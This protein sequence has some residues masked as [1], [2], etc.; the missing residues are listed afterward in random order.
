MCLFFLSYLLNLSKIRGKT[1]ADEIYL[2][3]FSVVE[4]LAR[5]MYDVTNRWTLSIIAQ[6]YIYRHQKGMN[7]IYHGVNFFCRGGTTDVMHFLPLYEI[8]MLDYF[9]IENGIF[10]DVGAHVGRY[11]LFV[12]KSLR[13]GYVYSFEP[14][15]R[16]FEV[17]MKNIAANDVHNITPLRIALSNSQGLTYLQLSDLNEGANSLVDVG[18]KNRLICVRTDR[19][20]DII[21]KEGIDPKEVVLIKIDV[22]GNE[23]LVLNGSKRLLRHGCPR[24]VFEAGTE[25]RL[26]KCRRALERFG[27][28]T[29]RIDDTNYLAEKQ[30]MWD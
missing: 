16:T 19:L 4:C 11:S 14:T 3:V 7:V 23:H 25:D 27:Y 30:S 12:A 15:P 28:T 18:D 29:K 8:K 5:L 10:L 24:I 26:L 13:N 22:E 21:K 17:L 6:K 9:R 2:S 1:V 20:D